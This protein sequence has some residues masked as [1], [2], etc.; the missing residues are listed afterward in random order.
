MVTR[1]SLIRPHQAANEE[2]GP[3][4]L[5]Q[6]GLFLPLQIGE[7]HLYDVD[8]LHNSLETQFLPISQAVPMVL[9]VVRANVTFS[10]DADTMAQK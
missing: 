1:C 6:G 9:S 3:G 7:Y 2:V 10:Q 4:I 5:E 8:N